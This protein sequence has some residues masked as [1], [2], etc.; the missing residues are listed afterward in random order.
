MSPMT[1]GLTTDVRRGPGG[2]GTLV[3]LASLA[4]VDVRA[5]GKS[6]RDNHRYA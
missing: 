2:G 4:A 6:A 1:S 5:Q 3:M